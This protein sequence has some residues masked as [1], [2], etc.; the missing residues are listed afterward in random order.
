MA[1]ANTACFPSHADGFLWKLAN[2]TVCDT[3][4]VASELPI[5]SPAFVAV[6]K[7]GFAAV[8]SVWRLRG[9]FSRLANRQGIL[10]DHFRAARIESWPHKDCAEMS[11]LLD[12]LLRDERDVISSAF[13]SPKVVLFWWEKSLTMLRAQT[14]ELTAI[15]HRIDALSVVETAMPGDEDYREYMSSFKMPDELDFSIDNDH[16][17]AK[18]FA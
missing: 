14:E 15:C 9:G 17:K 11:Q 1:T 8:G 3:K 2:A 13:T 16:R 5:A 6:I 4:D 10:L 18:L 7:N 12:E